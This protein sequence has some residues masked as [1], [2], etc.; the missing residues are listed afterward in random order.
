VTTLQFLAAPFAAC[1]VLAGLHA[2]LG[3][4]VLRRQVIFVDLALAQIAALGTVVAFAVGF[5]SETLGASLF[6]LAFAILGAALF[7]LTRARHEI[8]PQ[9]AI[10]GMTFVI[11]SSAVILVA[12]RAPEGAEHIKETLAGTIL[13]VQWPDVA[14]LAGAYVA[15]GLFH[16]LFRRQFILISEN[17]GEAF[18]RGMRVRAWDFA[19]YVSFGIV[20]TLSVSVAG[21]LMVFSY[22]VMPAAMALL[23]ASGWGRRLA[24]AYVTGILGSFLG[25]LFSYR[26]DMPSGPAVVCCLA[27]LLVITAV[28]Y[29]AVRRRHDSRPYGRLALVVALV[30]AAPAVWVAIGIPSPALRHIEEHDQHGPAEDP[31]NGPTGLAVEEATGG[32]EGMSGETPVRSREECAALVVLESGESFG[33]LARDCYGADLAGALRRFNE[34]TGQVAAG[35]EPGPGDLVELPPVEQLAIPVEA[36]P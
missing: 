35:T 31:E 20:I 34:S 6:S 13:W 33:S 19:F 10:I 8:I 15:V 32:E 29:Y 3:L 7:A 17:P 18:R 36:H 24:V 14:R 9:E 21:I 22:L 23:I 25:F 28:W 12:D 4:H 11:A 2:Y 30:V 1:L 27:A 5:H 16:Y 26:L